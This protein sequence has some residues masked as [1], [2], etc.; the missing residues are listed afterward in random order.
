MKKLYSL[1]LA[2]AFASA[3][4]AQYCTPSCSNPSGGCTYGAISMVRISGASGTTLI[5]SLGC[6]GSGYEDRHAL[7]GMTCT[8]TPGSTYVAS[9]SASYPNPKNSQMWI[10]YDNDNTFASSESIGGAN[11]WGYSAS[12]S[13]TVPSS[14]ATGSF[15]VRLASE[16]AGSIYYPSINPCMGSGYMFGDA[17]DYTISVGS[18]SSSSCSGTPTAGTASATTS[19]ACAYHYITLTDAGA[20]SGAGIT[21]QWEKS[22]DGGA[23]WTSISGATALTYTLAEPSVTTMYRC[24]VTCSTSSASA[25]T[26]GATITINRVSGHIAYSSAA[27]DTTSLKV[28]L[29]DYNAGAGTLT[30]IDSQIT[31]VD[32][33]NPYFEFNGMGAATYLVK[34]QSL[35][36]TSSMVGASGY[37]PTYGAS[38]PHWSGAA[39]I[40]HTTGISTQNITMSYGTVAAGP[41]FIGGLIS[42]GAGKNTATDVPAA[43]MLVLLQN[44]ASGVLTQTYTDAT[45]AYS[46]TGIAYGSYVVYPEAMGF[47]TTVY[48]TITLSASHVSQTGANFKQF[49][50]S[51]TIKPI[52]VS[53]GCVTTTQFSI[54]PNPSY[55]TLNI[56][57]GDLAAGKADVI[58]TNL[59]GQTVFNSSINIDNAG[60]SSVVNLSSLSNGLYIVKIQSETINFSEKLIL[61]N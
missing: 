38:S 30:A 31:C 40:T 27:P 22:T 6:T 1:L 4:S 16:Y 33:L 29:I 52:G 2:T 5:D 34:A 14:A 56:S 11:S 61:Q 47:A 51:K 46:F 12:I 26:A 19:G 44:T 43:N 54:A 7:S 41:G 21:Y 39:N 49:N 24:V 20:S 15:R 53:V 8:L 58:V 57:W 42:S 9:L 23:T 48:A 45:G 35:D 25:A 55:G 36:V 10:D 50:T 18:G 17:R 3:A 37:V 60:G 13:F 28:W 32:S 59:L